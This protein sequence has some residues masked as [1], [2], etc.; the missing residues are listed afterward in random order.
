MIMNNEVEEGVFALFAF[1]TVIYIVILESLN[2]SVNLF[3]Y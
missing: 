2:L 3:S 1:I